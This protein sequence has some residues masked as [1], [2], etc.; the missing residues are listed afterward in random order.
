MYSKW[1][2]EGLPGYVFGTNK[3]LYRLPFKSGF[4]YYNLREIK[5]Q[6]P[7]RYR[8]DGQ[9]WSERQ[10]KPKIRLDPNPVKLFDLEVQPF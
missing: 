2:I 3:K 1:I 9:W 4:N 10:L 5:K 8:L 7:N 6:K